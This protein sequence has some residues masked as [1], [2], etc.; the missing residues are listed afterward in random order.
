MWAFPGGV[1]DAHDARVIDACDGLSAAEANRLLDVRNGLKYFSAAI[2]ELFE[3]TGV[4][5]A[6]GSADSDALRN[7]RDG[8]NDASLRWR[9]FVDA[10]DLRLD[11]AALHYLSYWITPEGMP[12]RFATRFF[13]AR[14]PAGQSAEHCG[15]ELTESTWLLPASALDEHER[16]SLPMIFPTIRTL[17]LLSEFDTVDDVLEEA[18]TLAAAGIEE[19]LPRAVVIDGKRQV[20]MPGE[21][22]YADA[23]S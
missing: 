1:V 16:G 8:L 9:E 18:D 4:L 6:R 12:K 14:L 17:E 10:T 13:V 3:E 21:P 2:R 20:L 15:G 5:L 23:H 22:G 11:C 19:I 7:Y